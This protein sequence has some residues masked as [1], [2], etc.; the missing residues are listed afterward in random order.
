MKLWEILKSENIGKEYK[1]NESDTKYKLST[2]INNKPTLYWLNN[3]ISVVFTQEQIMYLDLEEIKK[4]NDWERQKYDEKYY[5]I[6]YDGTIGYD[7][8]R[9]NRS[10]LNCYDNY[11]YFSTKEKAEKVNKEQ[12]LYRMMKKFYDENDGNVKKSDESMCKY[13]IAYECS[14]KTYNVLYGW[15][16][17][18]LHTIYF[19]KEQ[20]AERCLEE[21]VKPFFKKYPKF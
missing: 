2:N 18:D 11:N 5:Y 16:L 10:D 13:Y 21:I 15:D 17:L 12:L 6:D 14:S 9:D 8:D 20:V 1:D 19:S 3:N 7:S 4:V